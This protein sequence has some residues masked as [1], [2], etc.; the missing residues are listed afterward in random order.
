MIK[1][2]NHVRQCE[3]G[4]VSIPHEVRK[5]IGIRE[6]SPFYILYDKEKGQVILQKVSGGCKNENN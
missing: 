6:G 2:T 4:K 5:E 3:Y 1:V